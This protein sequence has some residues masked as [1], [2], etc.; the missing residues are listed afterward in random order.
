MLWAQGGGSDTLE[1]TT[2]LSGFC[3]GRN[4]KLFLGM[5]LGPEDEDGLSVQKIGVWYPFKA[6]EGWRPVIK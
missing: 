5:V 4:R 3:T 1:K 6:L 2:C